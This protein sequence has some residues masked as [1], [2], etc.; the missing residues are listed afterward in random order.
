[1]RILLPVSAEVF[2][3]L[4]KQVEFRNQ[5]D[6]CGQHNGRGLIDMD[7]VDVICMPE[8]VAP[9]KGGVKV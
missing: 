5:Q 8:R 6:R 3:F 7:G 4:R 1:M 2:E 9:D